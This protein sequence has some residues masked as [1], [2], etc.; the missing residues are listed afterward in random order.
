VL[1]DRHD[2]ENGLL[3]IQAAWLTE[4]A[5]ADTL[6]SIQVESLRQTDAELRVTF[7]IRDRF[8]RS[9][10]GQDVFRLHFEPPPANTA[11]LQNYP[12]P[13]N[14]ETWIPFELSEDADVV[15]TIYDLEG[16]LLRTLRLGAQT[17]GRYRGRD[18][19][20]YWDGANEQGEAAASGVYVYELRAGD[21]REIRRMVIRK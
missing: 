4:G 6:A 18:R 3:D 2:E 8:N 13:F 19:A 1:L 20:A 14:P 5:L 11:L 17:V 12:N 15:V 10:R 7:D 21:Y 9:R 16:S